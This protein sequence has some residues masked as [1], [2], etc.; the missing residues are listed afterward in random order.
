MESLKKIS[1]DSIMQVFELSLELAPCVLKT[2]DGLWF[3]ENDGSV[4][5]GFRFRISRGLKNHVTIIDMGNIDSNEHL[6]VFVTSVVEVI[7][8]LGFSHNQWRVPVIRGSSLHIVLLGICN[9]HACHAF[10]AA[11]QEVHKL[12]KKITCIVAEQKN[13]KVI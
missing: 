10:H 9:L 4:S 1:V 7:D 8:G 3:G 5:V 2:V 13:L 6:Y 12:Q 11:D